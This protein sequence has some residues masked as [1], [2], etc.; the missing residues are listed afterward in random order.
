MVKK[1]IDPQIVDLCLRLAGQP[2]L[3]RLHDGRELHEP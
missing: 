1:Q 2:V 3:L